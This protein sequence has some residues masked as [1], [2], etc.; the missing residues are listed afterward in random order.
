MIAKIKYRSFEIQ[1]IPVASFLVLLLLF[2]SSRWSDLLAQ[3]NPTVLRID[4]AMATGGPASQK[5]DEVSYIPLESTSESAFGKI[6]QLQVTDS[7]FLIRDS[8]TNRVLI[9]TLAGKFHAKIEGKKFGFERPGELYIFHYEP[10]SRQIRIPFNNQFLCFDL[11]GNLIEKAGRAF[12]GVFTNLG[13]KNAAFYSYEAHSKAPDSIA[14]ELITTDEKRVI[15]KYFQYRLKSASIHMGDVPYFPNYNFF[16]DTESDTSAYFIRPYD[17]T[18]YKIGPR[19]LDSIYKFVFPLQNSLPGSF[20]IA[21][22]LTD[23]RLAYL[24]KQPDLIHSV[25]EV[26][27]TK[28]NLIFMTDN[29]G[30]EKDDFY[31]YNL[32]SNTL[33]DILKITPDDRSCFLPLTDKG[34]GNDFINMGILTAYKDF[35]YTSYSSVILFQ[36]KDATSSKNPRYSKELTQYFKDGKNIRGNPVIVQ[37]RFKND[38]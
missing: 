17:Y 32:K 15:Q 1:A 14:Y 5:I 7:F 29:Y 24:E 10:Q 13:R 38:L 21:S 37:I 23:R 3:R 27:K 34:L 28:G 22:E 18:V 33:T 11:N 20:T 4:P 6:H 19:S 26:F 36:Q 8:Y 25:G 16:P 35:I 30:F 2:C 12:R 31:I 9:F